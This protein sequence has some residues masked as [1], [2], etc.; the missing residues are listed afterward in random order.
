MVLERRITPR[1]EPE[2][3]VISLLQSASHRA[4]DQPHQIHV[5]FHGFELREFAL[6]VFRRVNEE[7]DIRFQQHRCVVVGIAG[8]DDVVVER[9]ERSH[10]LLLLVGNAELI[11]RDAVVL[12]DEPVAEQRGPVEGFHQGLC[13]L[14]ERVREDDDLGDAPKFIKKFLSAGQRLES[15]NDVLNVGECDAVTVENLD[16]ITH[17]FVVVR[18]IPGGPTQFGNFRLLG[19]GNP[20][21][22]SEHPFQVQRHNGLFHGCGVFQNAGVL[23]RISPHL[24]F[25][26]W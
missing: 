22:R 15:A 12:H 26:T 19:D 1:Q 5:A 4:L 10:G 7:T 25:D 14:L 8:G 17:E 6:H 11:A 13:E 23:S 3:P 20:D 18:F 16:A 9:L 2:R 21:F 24:R